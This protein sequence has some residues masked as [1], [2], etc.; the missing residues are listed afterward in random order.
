MTRS[1]MHSMQTTPRR[2]LLLPEESLATPGRG[3]RI[4]RYR[5]ASVARRSE[6][7]GTVRSPS[8]P[9]AGGDGR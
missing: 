9:V 4:R 8:R 5:L 7:G 2:F 1:L 3:P 6:P